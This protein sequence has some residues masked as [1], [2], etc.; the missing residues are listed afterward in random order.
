M[1]HKLVIHR[2][3]ALKLL[4]DGKPHDLT[5]WKLATGDILF[6]KDVTC[7]GKYTR[8][9][10]HKVRFPQSLL[11]REFRDITLFEI[12]GLRIYM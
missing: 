5:L 8:R 2:K 10:L 12:D 11:I 7:V 9:G 4:E 3:D 1:K 6:Y